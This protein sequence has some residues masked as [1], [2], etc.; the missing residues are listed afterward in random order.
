M[1]EDILQIRDLQIRKKGHSKPIVDKINL[2]IKQGEVVALVGESG[3]GKSITSLSILNLFSEEYGLESEGDI[4]LLKEGKQLNITDATRQQLNHVRQKQIGIVFQ[5]PQSALNPLVTCGKQVGES[6][7]ISE[8]LSSIHLLLCQL[9]LK[10]E[11]IFFNRITV[12]KD[13]PLKI[14][15]KKVI[16]WFD[17]LNIDS[18]ELTYSKFPHELSGGQKQ[19]VVIAMALI[20]EPTL[21]I[22]DE[23]TTALDKFTQEKLIHDLKTLQKEKNLSI[24]FVSHDLNAV[25]EIADRIYI[26]KDGKLLESG[27]ADAIF[28]NPKHFYT[29]DLVASCP[30]DDKKLSE[31]PTRK[32]FMGF[33]DEGYFGD[34]NMSLDQ[35]IKKLTV[36]PNESIKKSEELIKND[37]ILILKQ[38]N[39]TFS[40][41]KQS[42]KHVAVQE[43]S[44]HVHCGE[45]LGIIG[46][47]G[48]GKTTLAKIMV[49]I[50]KPDN[51]EILFENKNIEK[52]NKKDYKS[53]RKSVQMVFQD[54]YTSLNPTK[55]IKDILQ[56]PMVTHRIV[57]QNQLGERVNTILKQVGLV[58]EVKDRYPHEL[59]G[60]QR[61]R[62]C[63]ARA[64]VMNPKLIIFDEPVSALDVSVKADILNLLNELKTKFN[65][66]Y[67]FISHDLAIIRFIS[68]R[69]LVMKESQKVEIGFTERIY[70][71]PKEQ[72]TQK[73]LG[74]IP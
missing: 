68:D 73:L 28:K 4:C 52:L 15:K 60:G 66:T 22:A 42:K 13:N 71:K 3:A 58:Q 53:F 64:L 18:P 31:L 47:S 35:L 50:L 37:P 62:V 12:L 44:F 6:I 40:S 45:T 20:K 43:I 67:V 1:K 2:S 65:L 33:D 72:Y 30:P 14:I 57:P 55:T 25:K 11:K 5:E 9:S 7:L 16:Y 70:S 24:L 38:I 54:P 32:H 49:G 23:P 26:M 61:Q 63:I 19:R 34:V 10:V 8:N 27:N 74:S 29:R 51:G 41:K 56:E 21:L 59:S 69:V 17:K 39:K 48:S 46:E 36:D